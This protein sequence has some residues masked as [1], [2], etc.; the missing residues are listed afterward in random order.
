MH[1]C[2]SCCKINAKHGVVYGSCCQ[3]PSVMISDVTFYVLVLHFFQLPFELRTPTLLS[4][5]CDALTLLE[6]CLDMWRSMPCLLM[7]LL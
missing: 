3:R 6:Y 5:I 1:M 7:L 2:N 4:D